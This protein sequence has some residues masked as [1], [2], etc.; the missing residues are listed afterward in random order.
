MSQGSSSKQVNQTNVSDSAQRMLIK[1]HKREK[2][3]KLKKR[4]HKEWNRFDEMNQ[5]LRS[6]YGLEGC[7]SLFL[8]SPFRGSSLSFQSLSSQKRTK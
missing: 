6:N 8:E 7:A 5:T 2:K 1:G 4:K 3:K